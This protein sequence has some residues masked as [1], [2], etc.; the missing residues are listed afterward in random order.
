MDEISYTASN[1][2]V[3]TVMSFLGGLHLMT[4]ADHPSSGLLVK[5][6]TIDSEIKRGFDRLWNTYYPAPMTRRHVCGFGYARGWYNLNP[7]ENGASPMPYTAVVVPYWTVLFSSAA[8]LFALM[9]RKRK[10]GV[11]HLG[12]TVRSACGC[13]GTVFLITLCGCAGHSL[14]VSDGNIASRGEILDAVQEVRIGM[15]VEVML[16]HLVPVSNTAP[17]FRSLPKGEV[18][19]Y[20][21]LG[22]N[23]QMWVQ[24]AN[25]DN[26][27]P[28]G[29][30]IPNGAVTAIGKIEPRERW[31][32]KWEDS[33]ELK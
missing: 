16:S 26:L 20:F 5:R 32:F 15:S 12:A 33:N 4:I 28:L 18:Q 30:G 22:D 14:T 27:P 24:V 1:Q 3:W 31:T 2:R 6:E 9:L 25:P 19:Y 17:C 13:L 7:G 21:G 23:S 10:T 11:E 8:V 29:P